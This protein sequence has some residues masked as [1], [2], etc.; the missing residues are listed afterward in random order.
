MQTYTPQQVK[1]KGQDRAVALGEPKLARETVKQQH[2]HP[3]SPPQPESGEVLVDIEDLAG[4]QS[5]GQKRPVGKCHRDAKDEIRGQGCEGTETPVKTELA[6]KGSATPRKRSRQNTSFS[7]PAESSIRQVTS[8]LGDLHGTPVHQKNTSNACSHKASVMEAAVS[9]ILSQNTSNRNSSAAL[10]NIRTKFKGDFEALLAAPDSEVQDAIRTGG[11]ANV[12]TKRI[13]QL[14]RAV[15]ERNGTLS[16]EHLRSLPPADVKAEL[17]SYRGKG[18]GPKC[19]ACLQMFTLQLPEF[20]VDTHVHRLCN[21][22]F[23]LGCP[24]PEHTYEHMNKLVPD[25]LKHNLHVLFIRHGRKICGARG[26]RCSSCP[27]SVPRDEQGDRP[28]ARKGML[29]RIPCAYARS[30]AAAEFEGDPKRDPAC[31]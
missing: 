16:L 23:E 24:T 27:L 18:F 28:G 6:Q 17:E 5:A 12:K 25:S 7:V 1:R 2:A 31:E 8:L 4:T 22:I 3:S 14:L 13:K 29:E 11:L 10:Q 15:K 26:P 19:S 21:R 20:A 30:L 9:L